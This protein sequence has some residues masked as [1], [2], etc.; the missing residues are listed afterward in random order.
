MARNS[1]GGQRHQ[2]RV[3]GSRSCVFPSAAS[4]GARGDSY[5]QHKTYSSSRRFR[6]LMSF[7][8]C[9]IRGLP[10]LLTHRRGRGVERHQNGPPTRLNGPHSAAFVGCTRHT[11]ASGPKDRAG[12][13]SFARYCTVLTNML[14][15]QGGNV[16]PSHSVL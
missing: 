11:L 15:S 16:S 8:F 9:G 4:R 3:E 1:T 14:T 6:A 7:I 2:S 5:H 10:N 13:T 12:S